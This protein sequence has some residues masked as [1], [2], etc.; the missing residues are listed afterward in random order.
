VTDL[1]T[2]TVHGRTVAYRRATPA[3]TEK[4][5]PVVVLVHGIAG[6]SSEWAP[7]LERLGGDYD[8]VAPDLAGH[9]AST[10]LQGDHSIGAFATWLRDLLE[11]LQVERATFVG[12]SLGGGVV[13][14]FAYQFPE[15][16]ERMVL[17]S[18]G[19]LGREVSALIRAASLP[20]AELVLGG[21]G[22][23]AK[24]AQPLLGRVG[25]GPHTERG[26]LV[27]RIAGLTDGDRRAAFVRAVRAIASPGGQ[28]VS[29][30]DRLYLAEDIPTL[31]V[32]GARD[33]IIPV[34][35]AHA[36]HAAVPGSTLAVFE[37]SGHFPHA[38]EP[39]R[40]TALVTDFLASTP[41]ASYDKERIRQRMTSR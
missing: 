16:V 23:A 30:T 35:H 27:H 28:R 3:P 1:T 9:G 5:R 18:S 29:A 24:T 33:R 25:L 6:D 15:Y 26:E 34:E 10:R 14:Q 41:A 13:M 21:L 40:F 36:T 2:L 19:G 20:G 12:H 31:I 32:W 22:T 4:S 11:A 39:D 17:V 7:V 8:V 37:S 38:D